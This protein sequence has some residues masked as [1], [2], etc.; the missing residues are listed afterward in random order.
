MPFESEPVWI[1]TDEQL[2]VCCQRLRGAT[3]IAVDTEFMRSHTFYPKAALFQLA[4]E[5]TAS[6]GCYLIDPLS[7]TDFAPLIEL[8]ND[9]GIVKIFHACSEDLEVFNTLLGCVPAPLVDTQIAAGLL[10]HG[11]SL[12]YAA[13]VES[14]LGIKLEKG[15]TRSDWLQRPLQIQQLHYAV[16]DVVNLL[17][18]YDRL[19]EALE[20][21]GRLAWLRE[22]CEVLVAGAQMPQNLDAYYLRIKSAWKL[23]E[24]QL[25]TLRQL[26]HWR[27]RRARQ[28]DMPRNHVL[29]ERV[30]WSLAK[31]QPQT[32][33]ALRSVEGLEVRK[34]KRL[35]EE[36]LEVIEQARALPVQ[37]YPPPLPAPLTI[38][39]RTLV[40]ALKE[41]VEEKA[42]SLRIPPEVLVKKADYDFIVRSGMQGGRYHLPERLQGWRR[43]VV[44]ESL[45]QVASD[46]QETVNQQRNLE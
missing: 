1:A 26:S 18:L 46:I 6:E 8:L 42:T 37:S 36:L 24:Q 15:E 2:K 23:S 39:Q 14:L 30:L 25:A 5:H 11:A 33:A 40:K 17:P 43:A 41:I 12:S 27:E 13:L 44:G 22:D 34:I 16:Q 29:H 9:P 45:L 28:R 19:N 31:Q 4:G 35:G 7:I 3:R 21:A 32:V 38:A 20:Q 10:G